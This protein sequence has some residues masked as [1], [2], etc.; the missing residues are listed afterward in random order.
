MYQRWDRISQQLKL[1][2]IELVSL[3]GHRGHITPIFPRSNALL[4]TSFSCGCW[5]AVCGRLAEVR[6]GTK[7][8]ADTIPHD[9]HPD[10]NQQERSEFYN[11]IRS[12][13]TEQEGQPIR[14]GVAE[15]IVAAT[16]A[17]AIAADA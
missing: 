15:I 10:T 11:H 13:R 7:Q 9:L 12:S 5:L 3:C 8:L 16:K 4:P 14:K 2:E 6:Q 1:C 17:E